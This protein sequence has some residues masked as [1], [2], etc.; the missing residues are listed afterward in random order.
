[1]KTS[2][3][4]SVSRRGKPRRQG[5][6][7]SF[8]VGPADRLRRPHVIVVCRSSLNLI[9]YELEIDRFVTRREYESD[10]H[11][12]RHTFY[13]FDRKP[14]FAAHAEHRSVSSQ[15]LAG[16]TAELLLPAIVQHELHQL[17]AEVPR[18]FRSERTR[19]RT[20]PL[21]NLHPHEDVPY[22]AS[23]RLFGPAPQRPC[24]VRSRAASAG[25]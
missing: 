20:L 24:C 2:A 14:E 23:R 12:F 8:D 3:R 7:R 19:L 17:P 6:R 25:Q 15:H 16:H 10:G 9:R 5:S 11:C 18:P 4:L 22:P 21:R 1:M 13:V